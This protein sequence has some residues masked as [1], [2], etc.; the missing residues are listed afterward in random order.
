MIENQYQVA[1]I[2]KDNILIAE[3]SLQINNEKLNNL[4]GYI[5]FNLDSEYGKIIKVEICKTK[6]ST[7]LCTAIIELK[8]EISDENELKKIYEVLK[9]LLTSVI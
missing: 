9:E 6:I 4:S 2:P 8:K 7:F 5:D 3:F 1:Y